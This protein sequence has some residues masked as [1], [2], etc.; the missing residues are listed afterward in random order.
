MF[1]IG[2]SSLIQCWFLPGMIAIS[3]FRDFNIKDKIILSISLSILLNYV[4][5]LL[6]LYLNSFNQISFLVI[7]IIEFIFLIF[8]Y[9]SKINNLLKFKYFNIKLDLNSLLSVF[10]FGIIVYLALKSLGNII[11]PGDPY[12]MWNSW[13]R[14]IYNGYIPKNSLDYPL[15]YPVL[16]AITYVMIGTTKVEFF[17]QSVQLI[18][19]ISIFFIYLRIVE[20][21]EENK[22]VLKLALPITL[23]LILNQ[24]RHTLYIGFVDPILVY[25]SVILIYL[26]FFNK[27]FRDLLFNNKY[28]FLTSVIFA[29]PGLIKQTG[30]FISFISPIILVLSSNIKNKK[31]IIVKLGFMLLIISCI[32]FPWYVYKVFSYQDVA[33]EFNA[34]NLLSLQFENSSLYKIKR[35]IYL[36]FGYGSFIIIPL[37]LISIISKTCRIF[38]FF[39]ILPYYFIWSYFYGN[40]ARNFA[41]ILPFIG[42]L[43]ANSFIILR[44]KFFQN[45]LFFN[46]H[47][48]TSIIL[49]IFTIFY[50]NEKRSSEY[51]IYKN[52][53]Q[54]DNRTLYPRIN[55]LILHYKQKLIQNSQ[56]YSSNN[57]FVYL[58][59]LKNAIYQP[60]N[61]KA[62]EIFK[63]SKN[64]IFYL[65][66]KETCS[67]YFL[68]SLFIKNNF[69]EVFIT[70]KFI[71][72][73]SKE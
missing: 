5:V 34:I 9:K 2:I 67:M 61:R 65:F 25:G 60:C 55:T 39:I 15:A 32:V 68:N 69:S 73:E 43:I 26:Y 36:I 57:S 63:N 70:E 59:G 53:I 11:Y 38:I 48:Y 40:D 24:F 22:E 1:F 37:A 35:T 52:Q 12:I 17:A 50:V 16:Q 49:I 28:L 58:P 6:L 13:A 54:M 51:M 31:D 23:I 3:F 66:Q 20:I 47:L 72:I 56:L 7:F 27:N 8:I 42:Y 41:L 4:L 21:E 14:E 19:P 29:T 30:L 44:K 46:F 71:L 18:Y 62:E 10:L 33:T 45:K 64:K